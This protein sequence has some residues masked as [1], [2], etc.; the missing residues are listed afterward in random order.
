MILLLPATTPLLPVLDLSFTIAIGTHFA[1]SDSCDTAMQASVIQQLPQMLPGATK[2][3]FVKSGTRI[4]LPSSSYQMGNREI[5][6][7][8]KA[9]LSFIHRTPESSSIQQGVSPKTAYPE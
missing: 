7:H 8:N 2:Y 1:I 9:G 4:S 5:F 3:F 6:R